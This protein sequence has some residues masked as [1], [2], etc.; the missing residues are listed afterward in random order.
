MSVND[1]LTEGSCLWVMMK[2]SFQVTTRCDEDV[3]EILNEEEGECADR[4]E[5][6]PPYG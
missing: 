6:T 3:M 1:G 2:Q 4:E 5:N